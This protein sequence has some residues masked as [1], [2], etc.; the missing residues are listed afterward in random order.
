MTQHHHIRVVMFDLGN[1][2]VDL[3]EVTQMH[4]ML[5][6]QGEESQVWLQWLRSPAVKAFDT[7]QIDFDT[8]ARQLLAEVKSNTDKEAFK[9]AFQAWPKGLFAGALDLVKQVKPELH[10]AILSNTNAAHWPKIDG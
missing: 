6:T 8:F 9:R 7:G 10:K 4:A 2:L 3:G 1:V 5:N